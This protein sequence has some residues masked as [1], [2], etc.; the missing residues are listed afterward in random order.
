MKL[1]TGTCLW[2]SQFH[3]SGFSF[4]YLKKKLANLVSC[5]IMAANDLNPITV[6]LGLSMND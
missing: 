4:F 2:F 1:N 6:S 5:Y 3:V